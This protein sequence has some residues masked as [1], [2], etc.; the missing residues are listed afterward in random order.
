MNSPQDS[1]PASKKH[2]S[3]L[4]FSEATKLDHTVFIRR[5]LVGISGSD[6]A[7]I[8][9]ILIANVDKVQS[10]APR[11]NASYLKD[12]ACVLECADDGSRNWLFNHMNDL[13]SALPELKLWAI[14]AAQDRWRTRAV[15]TIKD[16]NSSK[17]ETVFD[18]FQK[19][20]QGLSTQ[21]WVFIKNLATSPKGRTLLV[22]IDRESAIYIAKN[23]KKLYYLLQRIKIEVTRL[24]QVVSGTDL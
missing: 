17:V 21:K 2:G 9:S 22:Q 24:N 3:K 15:F 13:V 19:A 11:F 12:G 8:H 4:T 1:L 14:T 18:R 23:D 5:A 16:S 10:D 6:F 7:K 20:N